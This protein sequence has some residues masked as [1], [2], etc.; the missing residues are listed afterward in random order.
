VPAGP[1][2]WHPPQPDDM[3]TSFP[4]A[5]SPLLV[6]TVSVGVVSCETVP[7]TLSAVGLTTVA[8]P[9]PATRMASPERIPVTATAQRIG[10]EA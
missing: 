9:Q 10:R 3:K 5:A 2:V 7:T 8:E 4:A 1:Y 6:S